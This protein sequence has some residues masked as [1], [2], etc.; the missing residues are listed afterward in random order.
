[1]IC[2]QPKDGNDKN[3][4]PEIA[5]VQTIGFVKDKVAFDFPRRLHA[6]SP[7]QGEGVLVCPTNAGAVFGVDLLTHQLL[8]ASP[9][10]EPAVVPAK[11]AKLPGLQANIA[12]ELGGWKIA[13]PVIHD[14]RVVFTAP[15][16]SSVHCVRLHDGMALWRASMGADELYFAGIQA[17][18]VL[19][20]G[21][22]SCRAYN[23]E[24][25]KTV[26]QLEDTGLP[27]GRGVASGNHYYLPLKTGADSRKPE[28][29]VIDVA[30]G[31]IQSRIQGSGE[32]PGNLVVVDGTVISQTA[33]SV[34]GYSR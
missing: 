34:A 15:D 1:L 21:K 6:V 24:D 33:S 30:S 18:K 22:N 26:W 23:L 29:C 27:S 13:P 17:G 3:P 4:V 12:P 28:V 10:R 2:L 9:Y 5:W 14:G 20:V 31:K 32:G 19:L 25:G 11:P 8:W 7:V 16:A